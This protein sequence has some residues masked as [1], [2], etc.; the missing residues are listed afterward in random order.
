M[1]TPLILRNL[2]HYVGPTLNF[3]ESHGKVMSKSI[4]IQKFCATKKVHN[5]DNTFFFLSQVQSRIPSL[6]QSTFLPMATKDRVTCLYQ[7]WNNLPGYL[8]VVGLQRSFYIHVKS[9][10]PQSCGFA[11]R[12]PPTTVWVRNWGACSNESGVEK[13]G[14]GGAHLRDI[15]P[16]ALPIHLV[17]P[18]LNELSNIWPFSTLMFQITQWLHTWLTFIPSSPKTCKKTP[19]TVLW[20][21]W[22]WC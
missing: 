4:L 6:W 8:V 18:L 14:R 11:V 19:I 15:P 1:S 2:H 17:S 20:M 7:K 10:H 21:T 3:H 13:W 9:D 12:K 16:S 5:Q 22:N